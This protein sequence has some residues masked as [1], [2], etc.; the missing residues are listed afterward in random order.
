M[1][2]FLKCKPIKF[3]SPNCLIKR[4]FLLISNLLLYK[5]VL[6]IYTPTPKQ[7]LYIY[8]PTLKQALY[9]RVYPLNSAIHVLRALK[10]NRMTYKCEINCGRMLIFSST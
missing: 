10:I 7:A 5:Q 4:F 6:Y 9:M 2:L 3:T 1:P 8:A